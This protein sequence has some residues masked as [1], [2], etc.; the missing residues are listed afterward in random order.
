[1]RHNRVRFIATLLILAIASTGYAFDFDQ[2]T[3]ERDARNLKRLERISVN[4]RASFESFSAEHHDTATITG[5][6]HALADKA[7]SSYAR[8]RNHMGKIAERWMDS[9]PKREALSSELE[10]RVKG[11]AMFLASSAVLTANAATMVK[12]FGGSIWQARLNQGAS[13]RTKWHVHGLFRDVVKSLMCRTH[14]SLMEDS[15]DWL[16]TQM[17]TI[18]ITAIADPERMNFL[19]GLVA[20]SDELAKI[21][22][23]GAVG[24]ITADVGAQMGSL[25]SKFGQLMS[26]A[27]D[28]VSKV[29][30]N[31]MGSIHLGEASVV[32]EL[33][34]RVESEMLA[35]LKPGDVLLDKTRFALTDKIIPGHFGHVAMWLGTPEEM[36][37]L[38]LFDRATNSQSLNKAKEYQERLMKGHCVLE[39]LR[40]GVECND[41][42][43]F[44]NV[45]EVV[46]LR[47]KP[48]TRNQAQ[49]QSLIG[50]ILARGLYHLG[51]A[52]DF[53]FDI[54][55]SNTIVC[56]EL[57]YQA[58]PES[59][60]W[61]TAVAMGRATISPDNVAVMAGPSDRFPFEVI[62]F[63]DGES[64]FGTDANSTYWKALF[65]DGALP[66]PSTDSNKSLLEAIKRLKK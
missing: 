60:E 16:D 35:I 42:Q 23:D 41:L 47:M 28:T 58:F 46:I 52:Y 17:P 4:L 59:I 40:P 36:L 64:H 54:N 18:Q 12:C 5:D 9:A 55:T 10:S 39:A 29:F 7:I 22:N 66:E 15:A 19:L 26:S 30:G 45:D 3:W 37:A 53:N 25:R 51:Q 8:L 11:T 34:D 2:K 57:V 56:S 63:F 61:P 21:R 14:R 13:D 27:M 50:Q 48:K 20:Y 24:R 62:Y 31:A 43:H 44:L 65:G 49:Q 38:G 6:Q 33:R 1:V 32:G